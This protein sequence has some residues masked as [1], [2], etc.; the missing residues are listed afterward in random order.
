LLQAA[1]VAELEVNLMFMVKA[2]LVL[3]VAAA[4]AVSARQLDL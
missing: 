4:Q 3:L 2:N 1:A